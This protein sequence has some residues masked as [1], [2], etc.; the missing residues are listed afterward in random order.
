MPHCQPSMAVSFKVIIR[1]LALRNRNAARPV[2]LNYLRRHPL[3]GSHFLILSEPVWPDINIWL[4]ACEG[5]VFV[6]LD[7]LLVLAL[8]KIGV[9]YLKLKWSWRSASLDTCQSSGIHVTEAKLLLR[10]SQ[11]QR[12]IW[13]TLQK[14]TLHKW[15]LA[16]YLSLIGC[17]RYPLWL[18]I[19]LGA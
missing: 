4:L 15:F 1:V 5:E 18:R 16:L 6:H 11:W 19:S 14:L 8:V 2:V 17:Y 13:R 10:Q 7:N 12:L 3:N 9:F